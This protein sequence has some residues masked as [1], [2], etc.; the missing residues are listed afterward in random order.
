MKYYAG[1]GSRQTP[2]PILDLM[3]TIA[4]RLA[5][6]GWTLRSGHADGADRAFEIGAGPDAEIYL[7][8]PTF[9]AHWQILGQRFIA[10]TQAAI[11]L[12]GQIHP[13]WHRCSRSAKLLHARNSHQ[14]LGQDLDSPVRFVVCWTPLDAEG[15]PTGGTAQAI[16]LA[17]VR[18]IPVFNLALEEHRT[19]LERYVTP[20]DRVLV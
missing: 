14:V 7:P 10:P 16:R 6:D 17:N 12:A 11:N 18:G 4:E 3:T 5:D 20:S 2:K 15:Q 13:A 8:W 1:I 19:R 9:N